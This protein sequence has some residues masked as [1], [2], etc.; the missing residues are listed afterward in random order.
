MAGRRLS[1]KSDEGRVEG[2]VECKRPR[3]DGILSE[4]CPLFSRATRLA[5]ACSSETG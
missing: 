1:R 3:P 5:A 2:V 4:H